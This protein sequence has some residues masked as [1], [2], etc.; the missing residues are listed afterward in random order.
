MPYG[1]ASGDVSA[2]GA[3]VWSKTDRPARMVVEYATTDQFAD[4]RK[5]IG[6]AALETS[7]YTARIILSDLP[8]GQT[9]V[10]RVL[11]QD[12]SSP[13]AWSEP[14]VGRFRTPPRDKR[15]V[16]FT[17][18]GDV[19][20]QGYGINPEWGGYRLY[21]AMR[22]L[23]PDFFLHSGDHIYADNPI[24]AELKLDDG[25]VW[26][27]I[28]TDAKSKVAESLTEFRGNF[29]YNYLDDHFRRFNADVPV[30]AQWDDH[31][32]HNN[33][34][35]GQMLE[36]DRYAVKSADL[37][38]ARAKRAFFEYLPVRTDAIDPDRIYRTV[39]YGPL[40]EVFVLDQRSYRGP[41]S[42]NRQQTLGSDSSFH[43]PQQIAWLKAKLK[44]STATWKV[45]A[46][47][48]PIGLIVGDRVAGRPAFEGV[49]QADGPPLGRELELADLFRFLKENKVRNLVWLTADVHYAT[50][51]YYD[52]AKAQFTDFDPFWEFIAGP[53]NAGTFG[54]GRLDNTFGPQV[55]FVG[56]P[57]GM[58]GNRPPSAGFQFFGS[59]RID[60]ASEVMTVALHDVTGKK[61][62]GV[63][64][65]PTKS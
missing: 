39:R 2:D 51:H 38:A 34:F 10:Y 3:V 7:D 63:E 11:F 30:L 1:V 21:E 14:V 4:A 42:A 33:W 47:D 57:R 59:V 56:I 58:R 17:W 31:E 61:L 12:L 35:P 46:S 8:P 54:P 22:K 15:D 64:L 29:A 45:I 41:N 25:T 62:Y 36:D 48:M 20:G 9:I 40:L 60:G 53:I 6:P 43:G 65:P 19:A 44:A 5:V 23:Q 24:Q 28:V 18:G 16:L 26:K 50:A 55:K 13:K 49:A 32:T 27:N 37:L 52:P